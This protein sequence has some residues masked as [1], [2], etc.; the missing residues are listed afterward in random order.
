MVAALGAATIVLSGCGDDVSGAE[1]IGGS[2][3][4]ITGGDASDLMCAPR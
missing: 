4:A 1:Q 3:V 2:G